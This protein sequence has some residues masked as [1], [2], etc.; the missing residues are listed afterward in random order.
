MKRLETQRLIL[1]EWR[2]SDSKDMYEYACSDLVGPPAGWKPHKDEEESRSIIK[3]FI[4][5]GDVYA[6]ESKEEGKVIGSIGVHEKAPDENV[7]G[8]RQKEIG[9]VLN[10]NYW[11]R[12]YIPEAVKE[13]LR[14]GFE[15]LGIDIFWCAHADFNLKSK[16]VIEKCGFEEQFRRNKVRKFNNQ[17]AVSIY[18][19]IL[20]AGYMIKAK[21]GTLS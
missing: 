20:R 18:Y 19:N 8:L 11:G 1:R 13:V 4:A 10:P 17:E 16:R 9:F 6:V 21:E 12:G 3:M 2:L 7:Q 15:D 14:H 5:A